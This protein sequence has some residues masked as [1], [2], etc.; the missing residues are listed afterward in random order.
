[1]ARPEDECSCCSSST[2]NP[3]SIC[4]KNFKK[5]TFL[6]TC[7]SDCT[8]RKQPEIPCFS[9]RRSCYFCRCGVM[10]LEKDVIHSAFCE[11]KAREGPTNASITIGGSHTKLGT[12]KFLPFFLNLERFCPC[13]EWVG[14]NSRLTMRSN[15]FS[16]VVTQ[17]KKGTAEVF[18]FSVTVTTLHEMYLRATLPEVRIWTLTMVVPKNNKK[19]VVS[20]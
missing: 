15:T 6:S 9:Y 3:A 18:F 12:K 5:A 13:G 10:P 11:C 14:K 4:A 8:R 17:W 2:M 1:M 16:T 20:R 19:V 7:S